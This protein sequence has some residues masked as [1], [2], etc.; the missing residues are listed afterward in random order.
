MT[1]EVFPVSAR[2]ALQAKSGQPHLWDDS[3]FESLET[4][5]HDTLDAGSRLKLKFHN[6]LGVGKHILERYLDILNERLV[7]LKDDFDLLEDVENQQTIYRNDM[8]RD[9]NF[10]MSDI[11]NI[12]YEMEQRGQEY[13]DE[14]MRLGRIF[15]L[16][17]KDKNPD[18]I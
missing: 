1:S 4:Y 8:T 9:F 15:E 7:L 6:P 18:K 5:I 11:E 16:L 3:R 17:N 13:F 10:R 12:L 14:T 2:L